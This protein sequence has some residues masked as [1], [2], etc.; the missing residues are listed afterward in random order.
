MAAKKYVKQN[1][2]GSLIEEWS[3]QTSAGSGDGGKIPALADAT[4]KLDV[5][6]MPDGIGANTRVAVAF[7]ALAAGDFVNVF[8]SGGVLKARKADASSSAKFATGFVLAAV[9]S[10]ANA[11]IYPTGETNSQV[12]GLTI[13]EKYVLSST[14][15][16]AVVIAT[17]RPTA[18]GTI[19]QILG[20]A[21]SATAIDTNIQ[22][23]I[24]NS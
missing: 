9:S 2:D 17:S 22:G 1:T 24:I 13:G 14:T 15:P 5:S 3:I 10:A 20:V 4:G 18:A 23:Y 8:L 12:S 19:T 21:A 7:E 16:G 11:T 6:F